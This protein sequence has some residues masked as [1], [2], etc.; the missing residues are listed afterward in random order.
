MGTYS[1]LRKMALPHLAHEVA[2]VLWSSLPASV[3]QK[4]VRFLQ[5]SSGPD[6][7][8]VTDYAQELFRDWRKSL[9]ISDKHSHV[10][11][12]RQSH[13]NHWVKESFCETVAAIVAPDYPSV[14][15]ECNVDLDARGREISGLTDLVF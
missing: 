15:R 13:L 8:E 14:S 2:H 3:R 1:L 7:K 4:Y 9:T 12:L 10:R 11:E 6:L 5:E